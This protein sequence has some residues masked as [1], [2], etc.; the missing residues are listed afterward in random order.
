MPPRSG[1]LPPLLSPPGPGNG[2]PA[3]PEE[4]PPSGTSSGEPGSAAL[5]LP[6]LSGGGLLFSL[7]S[8]CSS[9]KPLPPASWLWVSSSQLATA[10]ACFLTA[11]VVCLSLSLPPSARWRRMSL[12]RGCSL[13]M[14]SADISRCTEGLGLT[15]CFL[16]E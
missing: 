15:H 11:M 3:R 2:L 14:G 8:R 1:L 7:N 9:G 13:V 5:F 12:W 6:C 16:S 10:R 4:G